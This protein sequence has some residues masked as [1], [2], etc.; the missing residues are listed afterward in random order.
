[1][2]LFSGITKTL[3]G[4]R[5]A[6]SFRMPKLPTIKKPTIRAPT[7]KQPAPIRAPTIKPPAPIRAPTIKPPAPIRAPTIRAP[8]IKPAAVKPPGGIKVSGWTL[9][10][11]GLGGLGLGALLGFGG[12]AVPAGPGDPGDPHGY[13][14]GEYGG[15]LPYGGYDYLPPEYLADG[16]MPPAYPGG[17]FLYPAEAFAQDIFGGLGEMPFM[18]EYFEDIAD[19]GFAFPTLLIVGGVVVGG[20]YLVLNRTKTGKKFIG[21]GK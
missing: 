21:R 16:Y 18:G 7:I 12:G 10:G 20:G 1:M 19:S 4:L 17:E 5:R 6:P 2:G 13:I 11:I 15:S 8:T 14:G 3:S 9:G